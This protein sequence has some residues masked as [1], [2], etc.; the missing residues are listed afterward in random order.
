M[1]AGVSFGVLGPVEAWA[2]GRRLLLGPPQQRIVLAAILLNEGAVTS[3]GELVEAL[4]AQEPPAGAVKTI[5]TYVSRLRAVLTP[6]GAIVES[7]AGGYRLRVGPE[8]FDLARFR[9]LTAASLA[10]TTAEDRAT[11]IRQALDV[12]RGEPL[13]GLHGVWAES[14]RAQLSY[15]QAEAYELLYAAEL[16]AGHHVRA[17][18]EFPVLIQ[19]L[20]FRERLRELQILALYQA[21]LRAEAFAAYRD[22]R[23][24]L[25]DEL[26]VEPRSALRDLHGRMLRGD[27]TLDPSRQASDPPTAPA[28]Q[29]MADDPEPLEDAPGPEAGVPRP[30]Q[31]P[32]APAEFTGRDNELRRADEFLATARPGP[33]IVVIAGLG[34]VG[35]TSLALHWAHRLAPRYGDGQLYVDLRGY[36]PQRDPLSAADVLDGF[37]QALGLAP[38]HAPEGL[39]ARAGMFRSLTSTRR[40]LI[41][42]DNAVAADQVLD[43]LPGT[44]DSLV[45]VTS[46]GTLPDLLIRTGASLLTLLPPAYED[47]LALFASRAGRDRVRAEPRAAR[48]I[49]E[50]SGRHPLALAVVAARVAAR[51]HLPL[52]ATAAEV[53]AAHG[54]LDAFRMPEATVDV[55]AVL[56]WSYRTL[57]DGTAHMFRLLCLHPGP[58]LNA[59]VAASMLAQPVTRARGLLAEL[60]ASALLM[61]HQPGRWTVHDLVRAYGNDLA[62]ALDPPDERRAAL[63]RMFDYYVYAGRDAVAELGKN[64][65]PIEPDR[66]MPGVVGRAAEAGAW[67]GSEHPAMLAALELAARE[68]FHRHA[69]QLSWV[70]RAYLSRQGLWHQLRTSQKTGYAAAVQA[71][72]PAAEARALWGLAETDALMGRYPEA[73]TR[74][75]DARQIFARIGDTTSAEMTMIWM[76]GVYD[77]QGDW[78]AILEVTGPLLATYPPGRDVTLRARLLIAASWAEAHLGRYAE[79]ITDAREVI[80]SAA[81]LNPYWVA[82][83]WDTLGLAWAG[84]G[85]IGRAVDSYHQAVDI[86]RRH[87]APVSAAESLRR[88]GDAHTR[89]GRAVDAE[90]SYR[91]ALAL[92]AEV[93]GPRAALLAASLRHILSP[94]PEY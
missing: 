68:G 28:G 73:L 36:G 3:T 76:T 20:P 75:R 22:V 50:L 52:S 78:N 40:M 12:F 77:Q 45:I 8:N 9:A 34:G 7:L 30:A 93:D 57:A 91:Q 87:D 49:V 47:A 63:H 80:A 64:R 41:L 14:H 19:R 94:V 62:L 72:N 51:A 90:E 71:G 4:W 35:K 79:A 69:W 54:T 85:E 46:R 48:D 84:L 65:L 59:E 33:S 56:S 83:T 25:R 70:V 18:A 15:R 42:L 24:F 27:P 88:L 17:I 37:L 81:D 55:S 53:S 61:E 82:D 21:G 74:L 23:D 38:E 44:G 5:R 29:P 6:A 60:V 2:E 43:L 86:Y 1:S 67:F 89:A 16:E 32:A 39:A 92:I 26:G 58:D 10:L 13:A 11:R 31:L 66:P